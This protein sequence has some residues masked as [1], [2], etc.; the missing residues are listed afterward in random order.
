MRLYGALHA[1][2][3]RSCLVACAICADTSQLIS[4]WRDI[5]RGL[6][7]ERRLDLFGSVRVLRPYAFQRRSNTVYEHTLCIFSGDDLPII[8]GQCQDGF[9]RRARESL[10]L[11]CGFSR[12]LHGDEI[13]DFRIVVCA[14][15]R[16]RNSIN[17]VDFMNLTY[18]FSAFGFR[19]LQDVLAH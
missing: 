6:F 2:S 9:S 11:H 15:S 12:Q 17:N 8:R 10:G 19:Q 5:E 1:R 3:D 13:F 16:G 18:P 14:K 7:G 4:G